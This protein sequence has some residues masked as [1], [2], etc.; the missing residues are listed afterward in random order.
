[1]R[2]ILHIATNFNFPSYAT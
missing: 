2:F 1:M